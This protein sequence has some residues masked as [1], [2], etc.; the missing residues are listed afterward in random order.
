MHHINSHKNVATA[1]EEKEAETAEVV[2]GMISMRKGPSTTHLPSGL[3]V[4]VVVTEE[5]TPGNGPVAASMIDTA[6]AVAAASTITT[7]AATGT[8]ATGTAATGTAATG[9]AATTATI[10][11][12]TTGAARNATNEVA[13]TA[14]VTGTRTRRKIPISAKPT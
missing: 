5:A 1:V 6:A 9:T 2:H 10:I 3:V 11:R 12:K 8:A 14:R 13:P 7:T 4:M